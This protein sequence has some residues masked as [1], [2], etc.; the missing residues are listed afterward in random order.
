MDEIIITSGLEPVQAP[1]KIDDL[2]ALSSFSK[3]TTLVVALKRVHINESIGDGG[4]FVGV[5]REIGTTFKSVVLCTAIM[6][7]H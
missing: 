4:I 5:L 2:K 1:S 3:D 6:T 7:E